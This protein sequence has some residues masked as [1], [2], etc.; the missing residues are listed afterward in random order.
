[1]ETDFGVN[2]DRIIDIAKATKRFGS[3]T[4][5]CQL[6]LHIS[7][8]EF[9]ALL[10]PNG[11]GKTTLLMLLGGY[12]VPDEGS[13]RVFGKPPQKLASVEKNRWG[14]VFQDRPGL[15]PELTVREHLELY[16]AYYE[17][18]NNLEELLEV[19]DLARLARR[20]AEDLSGGERKRLELALAF[21]GNPE[22]IFLDEPT[23]GLD[24]QARRVM[25]NFLAN[26]KRRRITF[27]MTTHYLN[28]VEALADRLLVLS[29]GHL[30]FDGPPAV[31]KETQRA[32]DKSVDTLESAYLKLLE[33]HRDDRA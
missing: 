19:L 24:P 27:V 6:E 15:Y 23:T 25:W 20:G 32:K 31:L 21:L 22:L 30:V 28:E 12:A 2:E 14:F 8:G 9:V 7:Q 33:E 16:Q 10:G 17:H 18:P 11:A 13:V 3:I 4:A 29:E 5:L 1:M 26:M